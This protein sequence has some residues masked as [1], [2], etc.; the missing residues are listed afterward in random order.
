MDMKATHKL[1]SSNGEEWLLK[2]AGASYY[3]FK[4]GPGGVWRGPIPGNVY[5]E[6]EGEADN[7]G[8]MW[9]LKELRAFKGNK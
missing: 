1:I 9:T 5:K 4:V 8:G 6:Y 7:R 2:D 3:Y